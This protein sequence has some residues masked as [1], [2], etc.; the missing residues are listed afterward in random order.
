MTTQNNSNRSVI[1][2]YCRTPFAKAAI[3]GTGKPPGRYHAADPIDMMVTLINHMIDRTGL[4]P[5][6][7]KKVLTGNVHQEGPQGLNMARLNILHE[8]CKLPITTTGTTIDMFCASSIEGIEFA[9]ALIGRNP[10]SVYIVTGAQSMSRVPIG[11]NNPHMN[12]HVLNGNEPGFM[13][14]PT[15][16]K[17]LERLYEVTGKEMSD[18]AARSHQR[19]ANA[20]KNGHFD[21]EIVPFDGLSMDDGVR[22]DTTSQALQEIYETSKMD[23]K[24]SADKKAKAKAKA[25]FNAATSSQVTDG[26][27]A[28]MMSSEAFAKEN[29][30]PIKAIIIATAEIGLEPEVMGKGPVDATLL[31]LEKAG[32]EM[33]DI[34]FIESNE[35][36]A[37]QQISVIKEFEKR[38]VKIDQNKLNVDGG[39]ISIGHPFGATGARLVG[40][41]AETLIRENGRY[42]LATL[43]V[44]GGQGKTVI[45]ENPHYKPSL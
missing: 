10:D 14:M 34:D 21:N 40:H 29:N 3:P 43:C 33:D 35:A 9:D 22:A 17:N 26:A 8:K 2:D 1:I 27:S 16:A 23:A 4:D 37:P 42:G 12:P 41:L 15:T 6:H 45:I 13:D 19:T 7:V 38:G 25:I 5:K 11:G 44:G 28:V 20:Q 24:S 18:F 31:A 36:F 32:I 39:A 30:L